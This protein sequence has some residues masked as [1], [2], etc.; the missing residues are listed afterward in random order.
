MKMVLILKIAAEASALYR[1]VNS[2][3]IK[4]TKINFLTSS[5]RI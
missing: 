1:T 4:E 3:S 5:V 2:L